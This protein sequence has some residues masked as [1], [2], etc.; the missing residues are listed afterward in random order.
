LIRTLSSQADAR[1]AAFRQL[2]SIRNGR[3]T[4]IRDIGSTSQLRK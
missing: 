3:S 4:S 1:T 2:P